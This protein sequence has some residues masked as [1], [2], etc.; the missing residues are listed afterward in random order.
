M[1]LAHVVTS[2]IWKVG[3]RCL[4]LA[5]LD[6]GRVKTTDVDE[7]IHEGATVDILSEDKQ[8]I[9]EQEY[10]NLRKQAQCERLLA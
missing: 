2:S 6:E 3:S 1:S 7:A 9:H 8:R 4:S 10:V 5:T